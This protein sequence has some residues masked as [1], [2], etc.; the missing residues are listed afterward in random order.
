[1]KQV[2]YL[3]PGKTGK[4][5]TINGTDFLDDGQGYD[6]VA[7]DGILTSKGLFDYS[8]NIMPLPP[9]IYQDIKNKTTIYDDSFAHVD[10]LNESTD[11]K[12][13]TINKFKVSCTFV[14]VGCNTWPSNIRN[15]CFELSWPFTGYFTVTKCDIGY[16]F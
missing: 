6:R 10:K 14:W 9:A 5:V 16:E 11:G 15:L 7:N 8:S 2:N 3:E 13:I 12:G 1:V 4:R